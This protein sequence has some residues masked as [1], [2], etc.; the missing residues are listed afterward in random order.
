[1]SHPDHIYDL[2]KQLS[3]HIY[4]LLHQDKKMKGI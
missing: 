1:M 2:F 3:S 4:K